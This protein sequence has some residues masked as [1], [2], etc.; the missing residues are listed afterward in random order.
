MSE[1]TQR[2]WRD[3]FGISR[4]WYDFDGRATWTEGVRVARLDDPN[5]TGTVVEG[6]RGDFMVLWDGETQPQYE[7]N[8]EV[9]RIDESRGQTS[10]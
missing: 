5:T 7:V 2:D 10:P 9:T 1:S 6:E 8:T 4:E 3:K